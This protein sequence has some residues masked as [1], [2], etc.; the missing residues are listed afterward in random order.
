MSNN[1]FNIPLLE[2]VCRRGVLCATSVRYWRGCKRLNAEDLGLDPANVSDRLIQLGHKRLVPREAL[3]AFALIESRAHALV[4]GSSFPFLGGIARFVPNPR[5]A[6]LNEGL[7]RLKEE[8]R[9]AVLDF[10]AGYGPLRDRALA[11]WRDAAQHLNG[12]AESLLITIEQAFP[13]HGD[14]AKR[15]GFESKFFQVAAPE[16]LRLEVSESIEQMEIADQRRRV[17]EDAQRRLQSDLD[18]FIR[19]SVTTLRE[20]TARLASDVLATIEGSDGG[21]HQRTLNR[22]TTFIDSF[23]TLNFAGDAQ[24]EGTL[25][26]FREQLL[27]RSAEDY[28]NDSGAMT[29]LRDGL[30]RLHDA[31]LAMARTDGRDVISRFGQFGGRRLAVAS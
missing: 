8:F 24:L 1:Q 5:L 29:N 20:E 27:T 15:F 19:E 9:Q 6:A 11:E 30:N 14:I 10:V 21:V 12:N 2:A 4:E 22:L 31:A 3:A 16:S 13:P 7:D 26:R 28:R 17:A 18:G 23:R 25:E